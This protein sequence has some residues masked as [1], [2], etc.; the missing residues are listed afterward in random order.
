VNTN[1]A[2]QAGEVVATKFGVSLDWSDPIH[3]DDDEKAECRLCKTL[4][5]SRDA[6]KRPI[7][8]SCAA[9][10]VAEQ[11][12][13]QGGRVIAERFPTPAQQLAT[14]EQTEVTR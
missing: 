14:N 1:S 7:H 2:L 5:N 4:T 11:L 3:W 12:G 9:R 13:P 8:Q 10:L 6:Q